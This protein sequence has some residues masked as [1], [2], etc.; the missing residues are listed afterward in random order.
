M[1]KD[2]STESLGKVLTRLN[3][4][5]KELNCIYSLEELL[6]EKNLEKEKVFNALLEIL[7]PGFQFSTVCEALITFGDKKYYREGFAETE[8]HISSDLYIDGNSEGK[9]QIFYTQLIR[10]YN[11]SQFLPEEQKLLNI[12]ADRVSN[13]IF[14]QR[15]YKTM[16]YFRTKELK[17]ATDEELKDILSV[18]SDEH[19]KWRLK[20]A[21]IIAARLDFEKFSVQGVYII[22]STKNA[23][24]GPGSDI[25][26]IV[27]F[28]GDVVQRRELTSW[29][30]GW[31]LALGEMNYIKTGYKSDNSLID[32]HLVTDED[33]RN[34]SSYAIMIG[35]VNDGARALRVL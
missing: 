21:E 20:M 19:W 25:D 16:N 33:I 32:L 4:R 18:G 12:I 2:N 8:W 29:I 1:M 15:L 34:K 30:E 5:V 7:P 3:E 26:L 24:A 35:A 10:L 31:G 23:L 14:S 6:S 17:P 9:I 13:F 22:G 11:G 27:H 28:N